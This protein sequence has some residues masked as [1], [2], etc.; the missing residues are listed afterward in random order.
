M[1]AEV[2]E[3]V[4]EALPVVELEEPPREPQEADLAEL[5]REP[6]EVDHVEPQWVELE[7]LQ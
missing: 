1:V 6:Q 5:P 7:E 3:A 2:A 4:V